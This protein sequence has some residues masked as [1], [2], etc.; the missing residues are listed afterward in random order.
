MKLL[1]AG[2]TV[3]SLVHLV[4]SVAMP[5][6]QK[7][8]GL[9]GENGY[10]LAFTA[11]ILTSLALIV[12][13]WR[14]SVPTTL[15]VLPA[16]TRSIAFL[17]ILIAFILFGAANYATRIKLFVRH[18]QLTGLVLWA[19]AHLLLNGDSRSLLLFGWLGAWAILEII[20]IN[21]RDGD[22]VKPTPPGWAKEFKGLAIS[23]VVL[24]IVVVVHP[25]IAGVP[26]H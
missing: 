14:S 26:I 2:L 22:W 13:G 18:P 6:K 9:L 24:V 3:W 19:S 17:L 1:I 5:L 16:A 10:K 11:M 20:L 25:Y 8:T 12:F 7:L 21:R 23:L 15:Y 4:P